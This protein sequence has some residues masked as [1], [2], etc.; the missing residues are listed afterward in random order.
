MPKTYFENG[1]ERA[2]NTLSRAMNKFQYGSEEYEIARKAYAF[3]CEKI[4]IRQKLNKEH[5]N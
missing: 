4:R 3:V 1:E 2:L 5:E